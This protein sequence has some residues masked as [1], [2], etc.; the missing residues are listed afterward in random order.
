MALPTLFRT[1]VA[2]GLLVAGWSAQAGTV[3]FN[4]WFH[5]SSNIANVTPAFNGNSSFNAGAFKV[6]LS[7]FTGASAA[8]N[9]KSFEAYC[10]E[11]TEYFSPGSTYNTYDIVA[12][13]DYFSAKPGVASKLTQL[14]SYVNNSSVFAAAGVDKDLQ[15]TALQLAIWNTVYDSDATLA[16]HTQAT[17]SEGTTSL[18]STAANFRGSD[19]LL[20][21]AGSSSGYSLYVLRSGPPGQQDQL[22]WLRND[23]PEPASLALVVLALGGAAF[24]SRR[25]G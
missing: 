9:G 25:R 18:R 5:G 2:A 14:V 8:F 22:V 17:F 21:S 1:A 6:T 20:G 12:A 19:D 13:A 4:Q 24:A 11:L 10:V 23:V 3:T 16:S 15:S 7:N